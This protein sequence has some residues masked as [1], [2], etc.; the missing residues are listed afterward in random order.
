MQKPT[1][2]LSVEEKLDEVIIKEV[3]IE[4]LIEAHLTYSGRVSGKQYE[5]L[6]AGDIVTVL[7]EDA[8]DLL[9]RRLGKKQ[10]CGNSNGNYIFQILGGK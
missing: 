9:K 4:S 10:C 1:L 5:W 7:E 8:P 3:Q 2:K 6:K